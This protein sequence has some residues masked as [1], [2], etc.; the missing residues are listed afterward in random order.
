MKDR[1][2]EGNKRKRNETKRIQKKEG[3]FKMN[4]K[5]RKIYK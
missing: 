5:K 2:K 1:K 4:E 3:K